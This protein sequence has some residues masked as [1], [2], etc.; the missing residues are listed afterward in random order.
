[1]KNNEIRF[2]VE[3]DF[4]QAVDNLREKGFK[5]IVRTR[6][7]EKVFLLGFNQILLQIQSKGEREALVYL[8]GI[9]KK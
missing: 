5:E 9:K 2:S 1:M 8:L 7:Y 4:K 3:T 6:F